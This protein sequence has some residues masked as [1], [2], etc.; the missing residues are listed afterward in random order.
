MA[1]SGK[2]FNPC[3]LPANDKTHQGLKQNSPPNRWLIRTHVSCPRGV[4]QSNGPAAHPQRV[5]QEQGQ[6]DVKGEIRAAPDIKDELPRR[7]SVSHYN[8]HTNVGLTG[9][10]PATSWSRTKRSS[11]AELQPEVEIATL[12]GPTRYGR[13]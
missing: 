7:S 3:N 4:P 13:S 1:R 6:G 11:Q 5:N 10:E 2:R 12:H 9:F 8:S